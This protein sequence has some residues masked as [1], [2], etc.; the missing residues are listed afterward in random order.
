MVVQLQALPAASSSLCGQQLRQELAQ[1]G[2]RLAMHIMAARP[3]FLSPAQVPA[4][5]LAAER[6]LCTQ[7]L[8][9]DPSLRGKPAAVQEGIVKGR[10]AKR[11]S[12]L[13]LLQQP[14]V[15][16]EGAPL[17]SKHLESQQQRLQLDSLSVQRFEYWTLSK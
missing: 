3:L 13:C 16:E 1:V 2:R 11:L 17:V 9:E 12:E 4:E 7:Q 6:A 10:L 8:A 15:A 5:V 14:H